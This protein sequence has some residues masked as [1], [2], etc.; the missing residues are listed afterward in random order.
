MVHYQ[1]PASADVYV[2]RSGRTARAAQDGLAVALVTPREAPRFAALLR[3]SQDFWG[4]NCAVHTVILT[5]LLT[6]NTGTCGGQGM[7]IHSAVLQHALV[8]LVS[9]HPMWPSMI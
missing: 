8:F 6:Q 1:I 5:S 2:H 3:V 4:V 7:Y 9:L